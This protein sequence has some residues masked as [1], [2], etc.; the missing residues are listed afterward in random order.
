[1]VFVVVVVFV[2]VVVLVLVVVVNSKGGVADNFH[3]RL[4]SFSY[5]LL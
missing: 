4:Q 5:I 3:T 1:M 2:A